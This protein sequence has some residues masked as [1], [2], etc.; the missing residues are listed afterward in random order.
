MATYTIMNKAIYK[1]LLLLT[2]A[3]LLACQGGQGNPPAKETVPKGT[4]NQDAP[5][6]DIALFL[7]ADF[8]AQKA[9][10]LADVLKE[11]YPPSL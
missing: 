4:V 2:C 10:M 3:M 5:I 8:P 6:R 11:V 7:Y 9:Q 1:S